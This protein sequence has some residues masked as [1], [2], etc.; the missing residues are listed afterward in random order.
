MR[1]LSVLLFLLILV[2]ALSLSA[3]EN[4]DVAT[5]IPYEGMIQYVPAE[6]VE[7]PALPIDESLWQIVTE[8]MV[9]GLGDQIRTGATGWAE[10]VFFEGTS[11]QLLANTQI[12]ITELD[13]PDDDGS[14]FGITFELLI[15]DTYNTAS[16]ILDEDSKFEISMPGATASV[17][18]TVWY[19]RV[20]PTGCSMVY[21]EEGSVA[22]F[23]DVIQRER[24]RLI[25]P[26][27]FIIFNVVGQ[28][29]R[30]R[31]TWEL[32]RVP[33]NVTL[34]LADVRCGDGT[35]EPD[36]INICDLDM[37]GDLPGCGDGYCD[38]AAGEGLFSCPVDCSP[39]RFI[40]PEEL[41]DR[42]IYPPG[43]VRNN[44][45]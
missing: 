42:L 7:D 14:S 1:M 34:Q 12:I 30:D 37:A 36:E 10:V 24:P 19:T 38:R 23:S 4:E 9:V 43:D 39:L 15:G 13:L 2:N 44:R 20:M 45:S 31:P 32:P 21:T 33:E 22:T 28:I 5:L 6:A 35:L 41:R 40:S 26:G 25:Q 8:P 16:A 27:D 29:D 17:R 18:G 3:Q 11:S